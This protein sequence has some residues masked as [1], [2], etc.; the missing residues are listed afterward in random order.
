MPFIVVRDILKPAHVRRYEQ[1]PGLDWNVSRPLPHLRV[2]GRHTKMTRAAG[3]PGPG[4]RPCGDITPNSPGERIP[5]FQA[6]L[7]QQQRPEG[8]YKAWKRL[9]GKTVGHSSAGPPILI[10]HPT[11]KAKVALEA[12]KGEETVSQL[13]GRA[14]VHPARFRPGRKPLW[15]VPPASSATVRTRR[16]GTTP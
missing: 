7:C 6:L 16:P 3:S 8:A 11:F 5:V 9:E 10:P 12:V 4:N 14:Q 1:K 13:A 15:R 2:H